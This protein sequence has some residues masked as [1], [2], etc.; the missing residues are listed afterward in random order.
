M[1]EHIYV[2]S[3]HNY[4]LFFTEKG[5][6]F[7]LKVYEIPEGNKT[8]KEELF[9]TWIS[10]PPDDKVKAFINVKIWMTMNTSITISLRCVHSMVP[11]QNFSEAYSRPR[12]SGINAVPLKMDS[13]L[14][15][16]LT[17]GKQEIMFATKKR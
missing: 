2:A 15:A 6:C 1:V 14:E 11:H 17:N 16:R 5:R 10:I 8:Q 3:T 7:W 9:R 12:L 4:I 13:L